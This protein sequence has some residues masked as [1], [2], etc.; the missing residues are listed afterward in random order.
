VST[1]TLAAVLADPDDDQPRARQADELLADG[2][3]RGELINVQLRAS[4]LDPDGDDQPPLIARADTILAENGTEWFP[5]RVHVER[6]FASRCHAVNLDELRLRE[7]I[8]HV[9]G[10]HAPLGSE[11]LPRLRGLTISNLLPRDELRELLREA[12][13]LRQLT[14]WIGSLDD[15][16]ASWIAGFPHLNCLS[17]RADE[18]SPRALQRI[19]RLPLETLGLHYPLVEIA[20]ALAETGPLQVASLALNAGPDAAA[21]A[22]I[23]DPV[24]LAA[25]SCPLDVATAEWL[26][27]WR[28]T[29]ALER[30]MLGAPFEAVAVLLP[31]PLASL[32]ALAIGSARNSWS[33][34]QVEDVSSAPALQQLRELKFEAFAQPAEC[35]LEL[36]TSARL[37]RLT[38]LELGM[39]TT[40]LARLLS[41]EAP[42]RL[43]RFATRRF[44]PGTELPDELKRYP[45]FRNYWWL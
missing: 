13:N 23:V 36:A 31:L 28:G 34:R 17:I 11:H 8:T 30:I 19:L 20:D 44:A 45:P 22:R 42:P 4:R 18:T 21:F 41:L 35:Q 24:P 39:T 6:G 38:T 16:T 10:E 40:A 7:P 3:P 12:P 33:K 37:A 14:I 25:L 5:S 43:V 32:R 27:A 2:D 15:E 9:R 26:S 1:E 29:S